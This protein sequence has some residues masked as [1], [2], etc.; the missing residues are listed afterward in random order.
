MMIKLFVGL[1][2]FEDNHFAKKIQSFRHRFDDKI[3]T[4]SSLYMPLIAPFEIPVTAK[5]SLEENISEELG[6]FFP[7]S[8]MINVGFTGM[9][10]H[11]H[12]RKMIL[13]LKPQE[14][15]DLNY[16]TES[17]IQ[18]CRDHLENRE[19]APKSDNKSFLT[20]GR[21]QDPDSLHSAIAV[22]KREFQDCTSMPLKGICLFQ[23]NHGVWLQQSDL[24]QFHKTSDAS[25][26]GEK[27]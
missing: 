18:I 14:V 1:T 23:K 22:G 8:D 7:T 5:K 24:H 19:H 2:F 4:N 3:L 11:T 6:S 20:I 25:M 12:S 21:F 15:D 10:V 27:L 26:Y 9:D 13:H 16:A 17:L